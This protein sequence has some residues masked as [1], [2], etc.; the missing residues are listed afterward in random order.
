MRRRRQQDSPISLLAFQDIIT[1]VT[2]VLLLLTLLVTLSLIS[3]ELSSPRVHSRAVS[4]DASAVLEDIRREIE[5]LETRIEA[6]NTELEDFASIS[7][8]AVRRELHD[9][10]Q[11][12]ADLEMDVNVLRRKTEGTSV[13]LGQWKARKADLAEDRKT[14]NELERQLERL[15]EKRRELERDN[16]LIYN[17]HQAAEKTAWLV[18]VRH[19]SMVAA[20]AGKTE[21][22]RKFSSVPSFLRWTRT[23]SPAQEYFVFILRPQGIENYRQ[24]FR[25]LRKS[26][27]DLGMDLIGNEQTVMDP[28][29]GAGM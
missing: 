3:R 7:P 22:P 10:Q 28:A 20:R 1:S 26:D 24:I 25:S 9:L 8:S 27:Y 14:L 2:G 11:R 19:E 18:E 12:S 5:N 15:V 17:P 16:R 21:Q 13:R 29:R 4:E 23:R 6:G